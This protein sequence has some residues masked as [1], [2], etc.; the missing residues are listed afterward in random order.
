MAKFRLQPVILDHRNGQ[1]VH[2]GRVR[3]LSS[4]ELH[5]AKAEAD[6]VRLLGGI[7][8][9]QIVAEDNTVVAFKMVHSEAGR[10][11]WS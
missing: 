4:R 11:H 2:Y 10:A 3:E 5:D 1:I 7:N 6:Q 9:L 8:C